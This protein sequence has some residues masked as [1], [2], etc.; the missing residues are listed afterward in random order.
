MRVVVDASVTV[1]WILADPEVE[2]NSDRAGRLLKQIAQGEVATVQPPHW[3]SEVTAVITRLRPKIALQAFQLLY[4]LELPTVDNIPLY[5]TAINIAQ[6]T[7][8][9][10]FD[11]LYHAT[12][13]NEKAV[14][15]TADRSYFRKA[16]GLGAIV[17]LEDFATE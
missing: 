10:L 16:S 5:S 7:D 13:I 2:P 9:H 15:V 3:M 11:T 4:A 8:S 6:E 1:K 17:L 14:L 12:A